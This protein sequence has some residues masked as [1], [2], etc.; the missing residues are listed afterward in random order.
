LRER[1]P[2]RKGAGGG[3]VVE[4]VR[5]GGRNTHGSGVSGAASTVCMRPLIARS[6]RVIA[7]QPAGAT[8]DGGWQRCR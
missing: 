7:A 5:A 6:T 2:E 3:E 4:A 8:G 1:R